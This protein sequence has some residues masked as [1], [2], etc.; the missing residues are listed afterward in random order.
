MHILVHE[1]HQQARPKLVEAERSHRRYVDLS[2]TFGEPYLLSTRQIALYT[3]CRQIVYIKLS[4]ISCAHSCL[5]VN[6]STYL[7][8]IIW[9]STRIGLG[10]AP[11]FPC[12]LVLSPPPTRAPS[13]LLDPPLTERL[14]AH[15]LDRDER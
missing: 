4:T 11:P 6:Y 2:T 10:A 1:L 5:T 13:R 8:F 12:F 14:K 9:T 3:N 15:G 7:L